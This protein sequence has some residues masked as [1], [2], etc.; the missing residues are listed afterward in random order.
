M[1]NAPTVAM[2]HYLMTTDEHFARAIENGILDETA[3]NAAQQAHATGG[4]ES[5]GGEAHGEN[6][7]HLPCDAISCDGTQLAE[8][9]G[10]GLAKAFFASC[11]ENTFCIAKRLAFKNLAKSHLRSLVITYSQELSR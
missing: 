1:G 8:A 3:Q 5:H 10:T 6:A 9:E 7:P 4:K 2:R 11:C